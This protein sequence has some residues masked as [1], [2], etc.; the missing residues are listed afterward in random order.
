[1]SSTNQQ[2]PKCS[3]QEDDEEKGIQSTSVQ[4]S[5]E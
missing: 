2:L 5:N 1:M 3:F 4:F